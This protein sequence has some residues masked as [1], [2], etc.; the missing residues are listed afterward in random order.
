V[1]LGDDGEEQHYEL[2]KFHRSN[3][4]TC[5]NQRPIV[6]PGDRV[7]AGQPIA[8]SSSTSTR[9][10][11]RQNVLAAFMSWE[12]VQL[13][14]RDRAFGECRPKGPLHVHSHREA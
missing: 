3:Q 6:M 2:Q 11:L 8:D 4:G 12:R 10:R 1:V 13:R 9:A 5:L 14:G 7:V